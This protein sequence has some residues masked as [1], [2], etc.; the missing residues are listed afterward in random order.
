[1]ALVIFGVASAGS[2]SP[3]VDGFQADTPQAPI[4]GAAITGAGRQ[5]VQVVV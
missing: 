1:M 3:S 5:Y 2:Q 4:S